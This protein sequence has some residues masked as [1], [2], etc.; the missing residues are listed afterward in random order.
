MQ[1]LG[2]LFLKLFGHPAYTKKKTIKIL[3]MLL[4]NVPKS[5]ELFQKTIH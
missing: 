4:K 5:V 1:K 3:Y 2:N